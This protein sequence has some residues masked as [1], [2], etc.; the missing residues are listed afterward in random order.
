VNEPSQSRGASP[1]SARRFDNRVRWIWIGLGILIAGG[2]VLRLVRFGYS[3]YGDELSTLYVVRHNGLGGTIS[4]VA[5]DAE[6]TPPLYFVLAWFS[7][8]LGSAPEL[9]RLPS[10]VAGVAAIP[11]A[12]LVARRVADTTAGLVAAAFMAFDPFMV[13][14]SGD[15]RAYALVIALLLV[16]TLAML[17]AIDTGRRR[18]WIVYG[19]ATCLCMYTHYTAAFVLG[20]QLLWLLW[21]H[22]P[23]RKP[24]LLANSGAVLA[25]APW[26]PGMLADTRSPTVDVLSALQGDG[27]EVKRQAVETWIFGSPYVLPG[28]VPGQFALRIGAVGLVVAVLGAGFRFARHGLGRL[29]ERVGEERFRRLLL[30]LALA[31][32]TPVC[33]A[34]IL[35]GGGTDLFGARNLLTSSPGLALSIGALLSAAGG[36][37]AV[38]AGA[39]I[40]IALGVGIDKAFEPRYASVDVEAAAAKITKVARPG[41]VLVDS[42][43]APFTPVPLTT[44]DAHLDY[45]QGPEFRLFQPKGEPPF[46]VFK[47]VIPDPEK[48]LAKAFSEAN[49]HRL[50]LLDGGLSLRRGAAGEPPSLPGA[51]HG[52]SLTYPHDW[53]VESREAFVGIFPLEVVVFSQNPG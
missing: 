5:S 32:A 4:T 12:F 27:F 44:L 46:L 2:L 53:T 39:M 45:T 43:S 24:A 8:H 30:V 17:L 10:L 36:L 15:G 42:F 47:S 40:A 3:V 7:T 6:I 48:L 1:G 20:A 25:F 50:I 52:A 28:Q 51:T 11:L 22:P 31:L 23:A 41:D 19:A 35:L 26:I 37:V 34:A 13:F 38:I 14:Y 18:W 29:R 21:E 49:G 9:V 16:S 33:E